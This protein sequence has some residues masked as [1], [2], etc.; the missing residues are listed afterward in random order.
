MDPLSTIDHL[1]DPQKN[2]ELV[3]ESMHYK[4]CEP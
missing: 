3:L 4:Q 1:T 2:S